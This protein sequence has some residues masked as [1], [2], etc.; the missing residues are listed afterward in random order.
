MGLIGMGA[1]GM[2]QGVERDMVQG[3]GGCGCN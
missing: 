1:R 3:V 2:V